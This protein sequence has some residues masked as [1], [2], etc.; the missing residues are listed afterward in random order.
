MNSKLSRLQRVFNLTFTRNFSPREGSQHGVQGRP[1]LYGMI[2]VLPTAGSPLSK[3]ESVSEL[4]DRALEEA[5]IFRKYQS[6]FS[7][8]IIENMFDTPYLRPEQ[9]RAVSPHTVT[10][11]AVVANEV[12]R[13]LQRGEGFKIGI[14][15]LSGANKEAL[16]VAMA[17]DCDFIRTEGFV[18]G[19][20]GDEGWT[21]SC[22]G[23]LLRYRR[24]VNAEHIGIFCDIQKKHSSHAI[25]SDLSVEDHAKAAEFFEADGVILTGKATGDPANVE[26]L[27][28][29]KNASKRLKVMIGSGI[30]PANIAEYAHADCLIVGSSLKVH[31]DWKNRLDETK[32][33]TLVDQ[34]QKIK[35]EN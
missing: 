15:I 28:L 9:M 30:E 25:T 26:Q 17:T 6:S 32:I 1:A 20:V 16:A 5:E 13:V 3:G 21:Q 35:L 19:H 4:V 23:E 22:A 10:T 12:R 34:Y 18:F 24:T 8:V 33:Q 7:G 14:Q 27:H 11:M 2:H 31:D 29:V